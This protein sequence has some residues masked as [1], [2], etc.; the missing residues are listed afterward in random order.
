MLALVVTPIC[1]QG[2]SYRPLVLHPDSRLEVSV[3]ASAGITT[4]VVDGQ[5]FFPMRQGDSVRLAR[6]PVAYPLLAWAA[7]D[8]YRRMRE[9]LGW[10]GLVAPDEQTESIYGEPT[11]DDGVGGVL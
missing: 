5:G 4:L 7:L 6:H 1:P 8:P 3:T 2:L 11:T 10:S 9:R